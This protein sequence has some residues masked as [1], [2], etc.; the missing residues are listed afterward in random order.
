VQ[1][2]QGIVLKADVQRFREN[3]DADRVNLGLG[4]SF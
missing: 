2:T 1:V 3:K 4:W